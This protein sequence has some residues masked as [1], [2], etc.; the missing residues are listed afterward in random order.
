MSKC[1]R[2]ILISGAGSGIGRALCM[3]YAGPGVRLS[4]WG[5]NAAALEETAVACRELGA[6][7]GLVVQDMAD[8]AGSRAVLRA[9]NGDA[10]VDL[11]VLNAGV[12]S[13]SLP[14]GRAE[15]VEDACRTLAINALGTIN[16]A[17]TLLEGMR[18]R[19]G[20]LA[21]VSSLAFVYPFYDCA[22]YCA[23]KAAIAV[24]AKALRG[25]LY[26]SGVRVSTIY[27]G[28]VDSPMSDRIKGKQPMLWSAEKAAAHIRAK[29]DA[30]KESIAFPLPL[31]LGSLAMHLLPSPLARLIAKKLRFSV[32]PPRE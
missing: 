8:L 17:G 23:S 26:K 19:G 6:E 22:A 12:T 13:G 16:M 30:G 14:D 11:A 27:P 24:Y 10:P 20:H 29:L 9:M 32:A 31:A 15:P 1:L 3:A 4:L 18:E 25:G 21:L 2:H 7:C 5:R 28:Y